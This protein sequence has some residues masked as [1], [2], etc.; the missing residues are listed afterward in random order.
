MAD[1]KSRVVSMAEVRAKIPDKKHLYEA[2][3]RDGYLMP[4][5]TDK[6]MTIKF[7]LGK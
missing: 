4:L 3:V 2:M 6:I 5:K 7:M 1:N